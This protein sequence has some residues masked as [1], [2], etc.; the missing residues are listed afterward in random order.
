MTEPR[1]DWIWMRFI[2]WILRGKTVYIHENIPQDS[3]VG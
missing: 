2:E 3:R 1:H